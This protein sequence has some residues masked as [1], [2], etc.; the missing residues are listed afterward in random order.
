MNSHVERVEFPEEFFSKN[1]TIFISISIFHYIFAVIISVAAS[2]LIGG[3]ALHC[4][5]I[6][7]SCYGGQN[8]S[9]PLESSIMSGKESP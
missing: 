3:G 8:L 6:P 4:A 5:T 9:P 1:C 7:S 2:N